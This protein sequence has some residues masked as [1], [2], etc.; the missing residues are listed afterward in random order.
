MI[1]IDGHPILTAA[2]MRD[3]EAAHGDLA[4]LMAQAGAGVAIAARRLAGASEVLI[5]CGHGNNGGDGYVAAAELHAAGH[6]VRVAA[7]TEPRTDLGRAARARWTG[8]VEPL[9]T[10]TPAPILIDALFGT[11][12]SRPL[13][14]VHATHFHRLAAAARLTIA[15]DLPSGVTTDDGRVLT[16]PPR[17]HVT[18]ALGAVKPSHLLQPAARYAGHVR[19]IDLGLP[20]IGTA[21]VIAKPA[22]RDPG[23]DSHKYSRGM[24]ALV[25][26]AMPGAS[27]LAS[28]A[29]LRAGAGYVL[30]LGDGEGAPHALVRRPWSAD[31][32][33]DPRIGAVVIGPGLGRD[34]D[35]RTRLDAAHVSGRPLVIDGDAL[36]LLDPDAPRRAPTILTPHAGEFD[37]LFGKSTASKID[38][39]RA[40]AARA[41]AV[42]IFK[43][44]DTVI[45]APD[46]RVTVS[47]DASDWLSAAGT[48]DVLAGATGAMLA[49]G[50]PPF[51]A[52]TAAVW[53]HREAARLCGRSFIADDL[54]NALSRVR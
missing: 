22:F 39:A 42:I 6:P 38:R 54:A 40:A 46:G 3:A 11:G 8:L 32:L 27:E 26:G 23:P 5:I 36:R 34:D 30:H 1:Q 7:A 50:L 24:V 35:A 49:S 19:L 43:G 4:A 25:G 45:A 13:D 44:P 28:L 12:L 53:L 31:A 2:A 29:A 14:A 21:T 47:A 17:C 51:E 20:L 15:I 33:T 52:A 41:N 48:G 18:L 10:A 9:A 37:A 16:E